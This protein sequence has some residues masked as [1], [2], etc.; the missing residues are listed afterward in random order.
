M[1]GARALEPVLP[2]P[3][4]PVIT[5]IACACMKTMKAM[6]AMRVVEEAVKAWRSRGSRSVWRDLRG[7]ML[8]I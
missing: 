3:K 6:N 2:E 7:G 4:G 1:A 8:E 5:A